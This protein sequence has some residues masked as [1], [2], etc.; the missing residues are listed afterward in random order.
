MAIFFVHLAIFRFIFTQKINKK[1][2]RRIEQISLNAWPARHTVVYDGWLLRLT[3]GVTRRANAVYPLFDSTIDLESKIAFCEHF[4]AS[5]NLPTIFKLTKS[6]FPEILDE[7]LA[8]L[9]Y[10]RDAE[11]SV[12]VIDTDSFS[13]I[14]AQVEIEPQMSDEWLEQFMAFNG[15]EPALRDGYRQ[16]MEQIGFKT[17]FLS[18]KM[19]G[20]C[21]G[22]G[23]GV[24]EGE[25]VGIFDV[26]VKPDFRR[27]GYGR[28]VVE[29][30]I[31][32]G[33]RQGATTAYL[34]VM[35]NNLR[36]MRLYEMIGFA[37]I[38]RYW[39]RVKK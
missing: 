29:S 21:V 19:D 25:F 16:I 39:Y 2:I 7:K 11:T 34:Q 1:M 31:A 23:L 32:W 10:L 8:D 9:G 18:L 28:E 4:Y 14:G 24:V 22:C 12:Q 38:Y 13:E 26:V 36:A 27:R 30:L 33:K 15:Y 37:E 35:L 6:S 3:N 20:N 5:R 17:A